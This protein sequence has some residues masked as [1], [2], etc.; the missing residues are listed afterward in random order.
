MKILYTL[1]ICCLCTFV[2]AQTQVGQTL[3]EENPDEQFGKD[4]DLSA[5]GSRLAVTAPFATGNGQYSGRLKVYEWQEE[6]WVQLG[7]NIYGEHPENISA[8]AV[9]SADGS[10]VAFCSLGNANSTTQAGKVRVF[11]WGGDTWNQAGEALEGDNPGDG[12]GF[13]IDISA[14]GNRLAVGA[15]Y[16]ALNGYRAGQA[17]VFEWNGEDWEQ[18]GADFYGANAE[19]YFGRLSISGDGNRL[20]INSSSG[21]G[22]VEIFEWRDTSWQKLGATLHGAGASALFGSATAFSHDGGRIIIGSRGNNAAGPLAGLVQ[23]FDWDG[24]SWKQ[25]GQTIHGNADSATG[26]EVAISADGQRISFCDVRN[27]NNGLVNNGR[28]RTYDWN[29]SSWT[30]V[31]MP[32]VGAA[33]RD[34]LGEGLSLSSDGNRLAVSSIGS[35]SAGYVKVFQLSPATSTTTVER[36][37]IEAYPNPT[38]GLL[39]LNVPFEGTVQVMDATGKFLFGQSGT[40]TYIDMARLPAGIYQLHFLQGRKRESRKIVKR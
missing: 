21:S 26:S 39:H 35:V 17:K 16:N 29:G 33:T 18:L 32:I 14:D 3:F 28:V 23:V 22:R 7:E 13:G 8:F 25:A 27:D 15:R 1:T 9:L 34:Y 12:F 19:D 2:F 30:P 24:E 6:Q 40:I 4:I 37:G 10:R 31:G 38:A 36:L 5:D 20:A 11:D